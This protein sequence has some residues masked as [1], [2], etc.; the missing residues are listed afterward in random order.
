MNVSPQRCD[1]VVIVTG[2]GIDRARTDLNRYELG[3]VAY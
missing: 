3:G 1:R 2:C